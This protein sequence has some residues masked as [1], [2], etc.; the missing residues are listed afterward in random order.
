MSSDAVLVSC[1]LA[2]DAEIEPGHGA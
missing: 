2:P 1:A